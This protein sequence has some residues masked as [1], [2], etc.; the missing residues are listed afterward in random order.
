MMKTLVFIFCIAS[1]IH[2]A[3][4]VLYAQPGGVKPGDRVRIYAPNISEK[5][6]IGTLMN[7]TDEDIFIM[8]KNLSY[9]FLS[10]SVEQF[11]VSIQKKNNHLRGF[12]IGAVST[13][14]LLSL[15]MGI[16]Y[17]ECVSRELFGC[18]M[19]PTSR[20]NAFL[21]GAVAGGLLGGLTGFIIGSFTE[22]DKWERVSLSSGVSARPVLINGTEQNF[23][24]LSIQFRLTKKRFT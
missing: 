24:A 6:I 16:T 11:D 22:T 2:N 5:P 13:G 14:G 4:T 15:G 10:A 18:M 9:Y 8:S 19:H 21:F 1:F 23:P 12:L 7:I 3:S 20:G 17:R